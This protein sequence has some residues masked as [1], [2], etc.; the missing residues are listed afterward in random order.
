MNSLRNVVSII[1]RLG[2]LLPSLCLCPNQSPAQSPAAGIIEG[3]VFNPGTGEYLEFVRMTVDGTSLE[4][5]TDQSGEFRLVNV[6]A[7]E[8]RVTAFRTGV[9]TQSQSVTVSSGQVARQNF[10]LSYSKDTAACDTVIKLDQFVV[11]TPRELDGAAIT[12]NTKRFAANAM[13]S[14]QAN[15]TSDATN[16]RAAIHTAS[17]R[18]LI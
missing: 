18:N 11:S 4:T 16:D 15:E 17:G 3:R 13:N 12:I 5:F 1:S 14:K 7:G 6:P 10:E 2:L 8:A 9:P